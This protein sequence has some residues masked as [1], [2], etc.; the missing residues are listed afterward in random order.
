VIAKIQFAEQHQGHGTA[1]LEFLVRQY[2]QIDYTNIGV[3]AAGDDES[4]QKFC[5]RFLLKHSKP[6]KL[7]LNWIASV[8][9]I[10]NILESNC[11]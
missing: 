8:A 5:Q 9:H 7:A 3:E 2:K 6:D 11:P 4:I 1:L 10:K